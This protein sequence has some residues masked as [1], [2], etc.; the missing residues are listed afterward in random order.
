MFYGGDPA[1]GVWVKLVDQNNGSVFYTRTNSVGEFVFFGPPND[2][3]DITATANTP[4]GIISQSYIE[5]GQGPGTYETKSFEFTGKVYGQVTLGSGSV[6]GASIDIYAPNGSLGVAYSVSGGYFSFLTSVAGNYKMAA[7]LGSYASSAYTDYVY[8]NT[9]TEQNFSLGPEFDITFAESGLSG[10]QWS[11][12]LSGQNVPGANGSQT[13]STTGTS[14]TFSEPEDSTYDYTVGVPSGY[15]ANSS[16]GSV[17]VGTS[18]ITVDISFTESGYSATF[19][20]SG[21]PS[22]STWYAYL[23][24]KEG[25]ALAG[26]S[27][28]ITGASSLSFS[29]PGIAIKESNG[30]T[31]KYTPSPS[32][33]T[34]TNGGT[35]SISFHLSEVC[36]GSICAVESVN[37]TTPILL[38][39]GT[40]AFAENITAGTEVMSYNISSGSFIPESVLNVIID[41]HSRMIMIDGYIG[42]SYNQ[43]VWT[44]HGYVT[45][46]NLT[47]GDEIVDVFTGHYIRVHSIDLEL[48]HFTMYDFELSG[49]NDYIAW[50]YVLETGD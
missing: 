47:V 45:A 42:I 10:N 5:Y 22:G 15:L 30:D 39:N 28:T 19:K 12:T 18:S 50:Q 34:A 7:Y 38:A 23:G 4:W 35:V 20:E 1:A 8:L 21:L 26:S 17:Y 6:S 49:I 9:D 25:Q 46:G 32:S 24:S 13:Q 43:S 40:Y 31:Y 36:Y 2:T 48:G 37:G 29:I 14:I 16:S 27:I 3:Y 33:G 11:I 44:N 41:T